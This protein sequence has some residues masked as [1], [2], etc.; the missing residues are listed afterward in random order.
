M[1]RIFK[2]LLRQSLQKISYNV[3]ITRKLYD[4]GTG[5]ILSGVAEPKLFISDSGSI[6]VPY[7]GAGSD[8]DSSSSHL[9]QLKTV[10]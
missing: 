1:S 2:I 3:Y 6:F 7:F 8:S 5:T 10:P 4:L 9:L